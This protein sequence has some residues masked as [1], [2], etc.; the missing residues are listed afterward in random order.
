[1]SLEDRDPLDLRARRDD[2][3]EEERQQPPLDI[4][5]LRLLPAR[6][7]HVPEAHQGCSW[8]VNGVSMPHDGHV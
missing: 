8:I 2:Q 5:V 7:V 6:P 3:R 4:V 1:M